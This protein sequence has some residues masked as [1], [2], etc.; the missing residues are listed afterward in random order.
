V[1][2]VDVAL[3]VIAYAVGVAEGD[4]AGEAS[5]RMMGSKPDLLEAVRIRGNEMAA[6]ASVEVLRK[7]RRV[8]MRVLR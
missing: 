2:D 3:R 4:V 8:G 7:A 5:P 1:L 6:A